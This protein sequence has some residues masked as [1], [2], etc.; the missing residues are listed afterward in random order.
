[1]EN[2]QHVY[3]HVPFC[4]RR[5]SYCDFSIAVRQ[6]VP[7]D[8]YVESVIGELRARSIRIAPGSL[9]TLYL[10]GG[11][12]SLLGPAGIGDLIRRFGEESGVGDLSTLLWKNT[13]VTL[14][15]N[16]EDVS[17]DAVRAWHSAGVNR[18]SLGV[19]SFDSQVLDW[20]H[21]GHDAEGTAEAIRVLRGE[22][23]ADLSVD[24]I[25]GIPEAMGRDWERDLELAL[26]LEPTH[27]SVYGL[28]VE[29]HTPLGR[30]A[31][32]G[33]VRE[34]PEERH[35]EE[36]LRANDRLTGAGFDHY[37]VSNYSRRSH[38][39]RHNSAYWTRVP[40][41]GLGPSAHG[42]DGAVRRWN[43]GPYA[44]WSA[45]ASV[46]RDPVDG[47]E[48]LGPE[49]RAAEEVYLGLR[50]VD[51][52]SVHQ[53]DITTV[54]AWLDQGW[55]VLDPAGRLRLTPEGWLRLDALAAA[56]TSARSRS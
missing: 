28:T 56:L 14:E 17:A 38:R 34:A 36:F 44:S 42:F 52:L 41:L 43:L 24:L 25:A 21:R 26:A 5:C 45:S 12:P 6:A 16:P 11:T 1:M 7:V 53:N 2:F 48:R 32:R 39:A 27:L 19:Q 54:T 20:M 55:A 9:K 51:G 30:W 8:K 50:T 4:R 23:I 29:P 15:A 31:A 49:E 13:E 10:G 47:S 3:I 33:E 18:V 46:G 37:E 40:Y 35:A 22:G